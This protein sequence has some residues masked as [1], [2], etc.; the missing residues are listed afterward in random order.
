MAKSWRVLGLIG[1]L[2]V[3]SLDSGAQRFAIAFE[4]TRNL[5]EAMARENH[6]G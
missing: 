1:A 2:L 4:T 6:E 5:D 3:V